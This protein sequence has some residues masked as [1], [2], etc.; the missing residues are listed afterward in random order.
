MQRTG[1]F[2]EILTAFA[3]AI[4]PGAA[5]IRDQLL[6]YWRIFLF[7]ELLRALYAFVWSGRLLESTLATLGRG[8]LVYWALLNFPELLEWTQQ[9]L[10]ALGLLAGQNRITLAQY[11]DPGSYL[12]QGMNVASLLYSTMTASF[13][14]TTMAMAIGY[15]FLWMAMMAAFGIMALNIAIWQVEL[16]IAG[17]A[18]LVLLPT[19]AFRSWAWMAQGALSLVLNLTFRFF[20]GALLASLSFPVLERLTI[21]QP[22]SFQSVIVSVLGGWL[23]ATL[24]FQVNR[25]SSHFLAGM[26]SLSA[27][28]VISSAIGS[29]ITAGAA[30]SGAMG[31]G[32]GATAGALGA[33][34]G[35]AGLIG[36]GRGAVSALA[37]GSGMRGAAT[38]A[39][40][41]ARSAMS[42]P[43]MSRVGSY[44]GSSAGVASRQGQ[45]SL[46][47]FADVGR[48]IA[49]DGAGVGIRR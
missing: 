18:V 20:L 34:R 7:F 5:S 17:L 25:L 30:I 29:A 38:A 26:A 41:G 46:R 47:Q 32:A 1:I 19:L 44:A 22:V 31:I 23:F 2:Q 37:S 16:L 14:L 6:F 10:S 9:T 4:Q 15:F 42:S 27:G 48:F 40:A 12:N 13:G 24:F 21:T 49:Q 39:G 43:L 3:D 33:A 45:R 11:L 28:T 36:A 8:A 35:T